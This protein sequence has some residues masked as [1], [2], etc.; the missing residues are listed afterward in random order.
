MTGNC[1][2]CGAPCAEGNDW[3]EAREQ[4]DA[5]TVLAVLRGGRGDD[6]AGRW[7]TTCSGPDWAGE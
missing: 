2:K 4:A 5:V 7:V 6:P 1:G 3:C